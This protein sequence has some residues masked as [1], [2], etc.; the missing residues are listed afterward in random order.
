MAISTIG[1]G[2]SSSGGTIAPMGARLAV[3][4]SSSTG[5]Y[6][7]TLPAGDFH[8][9]GGVGSKITFSDG[10]TINMSYNWS[11][12]TGVQV[13][14]SPQNSGTFFRNPSSQTMTVTAGAVPITRRLGSILSVGNTATRYYYRNR[15]SYIASAGKYVFPDS[16]NNTVWTSSDALNW[17]STATSFTVGDCYMVANGVLFAG[18]AGFTNTFYYST[19]GTSFTQVSLPTG[20][21]ADGHLV[22][23]V[24]ASGNYVAFVRR[25][26]VNAY[27]VHTFTSSN[28]TTW[29]YGAQVT[30]V[31]YNNILADINVASDGTTIVISNDGYSSNSSLAYSTN[32]T[33]WTSGYGPAGTAYFFSRLEYVNGRFV[34]VFTSNTTSNGMIMYSTNGTSWNQTYFSSTSFGY[35]SAN[36][37]SGI[38]WDGT[39]YLFTS[40]YVGNS[41]T[42][43]TAITMNAIP[44]TDTGTTLWSFYLGSGSTK[45][46]FGWSG[47]ANGKFFIRADDGAPNGGTFTWLCNSSIVSPTAPN[48]FSI[49][50]YHDN[51]TL[52]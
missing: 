23:V 39:Q 24:Y 12:S 35:Q 41:S 52:N 45:P 29:T 9:I 21:I 31:T 36:C 48:S 14:G 25:G 44:G 30:A 11:Y 49:Y 19:N 10:A 7:A 37:L 43:P 6:S 51:I 27:A 17:T 28:L 34:G 1:G 47:S 40:N 2:A 33:S 16:T 20:T 3:G 26:T 50:K 4:G 5:T 15:I 46:Y 38:T 18:D 22:A 8:F 13:N 42:Q 32:G